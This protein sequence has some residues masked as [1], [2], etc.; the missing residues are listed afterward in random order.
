MGE[1]RSLQQMVLRELDSCMQK[2]GTEP[3]SYTIHKNKFK[4]MKDLNVRQV[5]GTEVGT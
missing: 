4:W 1:R 3:L 5:T 2:N